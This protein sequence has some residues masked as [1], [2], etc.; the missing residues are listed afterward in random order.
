MRLGL[1]YLK[2]TGVQKDPKEA[3]KYLQLASREQQ[4]GF[5]NLLA[6]WYMA[7]IHS[8]GIGTLEYFSKFDIYDKKPFGIK[9]LLKVFYQI[10]TVLSRI[11]NTLLSMEFG[12]GYF[13]IHGVCG[14][15]K[16]LTPLTLCIRI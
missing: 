7:E 8:R 9:I 10:V 6:F 2:G 11:I 13:Y 1:A 12:T 14:K 3:Y 5:G 4:A 15:I 16:M